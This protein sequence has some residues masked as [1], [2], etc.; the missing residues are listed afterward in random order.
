MQ[1]YRI[2]WLFTLIVAASLACNFLSGI[3]E[4]LGEVRNTAEAAATQVQEVVDQAQGLATAVESSGI[5]QTAQALA[6][7]QG[8]QL[9]GTAQALAT[10]AKESGFIETAQAKATEGVSFGEA[11]EDIPV[12]DEENVV[13][14]FGSENIVS[15]NSVLDFQ[16][17]VEFYQREM[18]LNGWTPVTRESQVEGNSAVLD[19]EKLGRTASV[20][21]NR[22]PLDNGAIVLIMIQDR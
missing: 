10:E 2:A 3:R 17:V 20:A 13:N 16:T 4:D 6:T 21:L 11:P 18:P 5:L 12:I 15:Y 19:F 1:K 9:I 8:G 22:N 7:N 14:F